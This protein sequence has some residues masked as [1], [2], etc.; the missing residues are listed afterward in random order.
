MLMHRYTKSLRCLA[1]RFLVELT[2]RNTPQA[3]TPYSEG[4]RKETSHF[5]FIVPGHNSERG[6]RYRF[7]FLVVSRFNEEKDK[8]LCEGFSRCV[9]DNDGVYLVRN[10]PSWT[11][12]G[13]DLASSMF[14]K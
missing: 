4:I 12:Y 11:P 14:F 1:V 6:I 5:E 13:F 10:I 2:G 8:C 7:Y 3:A 9:R